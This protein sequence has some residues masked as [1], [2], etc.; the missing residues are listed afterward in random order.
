MKILVTGGCGLIGYHVTKH[1][2]EQGHNVYVMD[3]LERSKLLGHTVSEERERYNLNK[4]V[5]MGA[6][7]FELDVAEAD[8]FAGMPYFDII[9]HF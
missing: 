9:V 5:E 2:L 7:M 4:L 6:L 8:S 3:N 1:Y